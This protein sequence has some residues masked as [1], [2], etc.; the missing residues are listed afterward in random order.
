MKRIDVHVHPPLITSL[1]GLVYH[2]VE[3]RIARNAGFAIVIGACRTTYL[4]K[5]LINPA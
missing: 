1:L 5:S 2:M 4:M 3:A